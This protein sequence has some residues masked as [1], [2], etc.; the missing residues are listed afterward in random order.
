MHALQ[1]LPIVSYHLLKNTKLTIAFS[2]LYGLLALT[3][4]IQALKGRPLF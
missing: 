3:T 4:L 1:V 2:L